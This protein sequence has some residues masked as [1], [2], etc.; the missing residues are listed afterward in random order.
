MFVGKDVFNLN[1]LCLKQIVIP[2]LPT[3]V[4][5]VCEARQ[6]MW[7]RPTLVCD[8]KEVAFLTGVMVMFE[9]NDL[10]YIR[11]FYLWDDKAIWCWFR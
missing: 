9:F 10:P 3:K 2:Q 6:R 5:K 1:L 4:L 8:P 11:K 7:V